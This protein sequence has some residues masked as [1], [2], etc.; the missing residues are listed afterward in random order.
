[1]LASITYLLIRALLRLLM[2]SSS[3]ERQTELELVVLRHELNVLRRQVKRP[4]LRP[5]DR[6]LLSAC[7]RRMPRASWTCFFVTPKTL[8]RWHR[9]LIRRR[10]SRYAR[11]RKGR[12]P[13][14]SDI[15][16]LVLRLARENQRW[17]YKRIQG[18]LKALGIEISASTIRTLLRR[19]G[20]G[21]APRRGEVTWRQF[22]T[23]QA[24]GI[25]AC[26]FFTVETLWLKRIYVL[27]FIEHSSRR[28]HFAGCISRPH[29]AW[30]TQQARNTVTHFDER[31]SH[32]QFLIRDRD[33]KFAAS[34]DEVFRTEG[35]EIV[36]T[37]IR[38]P[39][40]NAFAE[41]WVRTI[42]TECLDWVLIISRRHLERVV[43]IYI[44]HY[45]RHRPHR[46]LDLQ[47]PDP[48]RLEERE[49]LSVASSVR[50]R[51]RLGGLIHEYYEE[52]A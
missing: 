47:S 40:A 19:H 3:G 10:W 27:F 51:D 11:R 29:A 43:R 21:P 45:N 20:L 24:H 22:L 15:K 4:T 25:I 41:R 14:S 52:A 42:R 26:D 1:M 39:K 44:D 48:E 18:E 5:R 38:A 46:S 9:E 13:F 8:L 35:L 28:V 30:I 34:F 31:D 16:E 32:F 33:T 12:P 6:A 50:R 23:Q 49:S 36:R 2:P 7:A 17:G 37:P